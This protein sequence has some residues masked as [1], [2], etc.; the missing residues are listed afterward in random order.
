MKLSELLDAKAIDLKAKAATKDEALDVLIGLHEKAG[1]LK[2]VEA[3]REAIAAREALGSTA[4]SE[5][6]AV[7]HA[8]CDA[9]A[10]PALAA[11]VVPDGVDYGAED[12]PV[13]LL[14]MIAGPEDGA[15]HLE[16]LS[17]LVTALGDSSFRTDLMAAQ[18][19]EE[20]IATVA[21]KDK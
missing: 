14:F 10:N 1:N 17:S 6:L 20:F 13:K 19:V 16:V 7:P 4:V 15:A 18:T 21:K 3:F 2:D 11:I 9:V 5:G 8:H 12:G